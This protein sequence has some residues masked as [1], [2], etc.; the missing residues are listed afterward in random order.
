MKVRLKRNNEEPSFDLY[1]AGTIKQNI[2]KKQQKAPIMIDF[3]TPKILAI[4][5]D[6]KLKIEKKKYKKANE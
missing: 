6:R 3:L 2:Q 5:V 1:R 4:A